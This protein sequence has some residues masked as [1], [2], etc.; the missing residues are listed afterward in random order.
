MGGPH[1]VSTNGPPNIEVLH[2]QHQQWQHR[3]HPPPSRPQ[4]PD[5]RTPTSAMVSQPAVF[6]MPFDGVDGS[7]TSVPYLPQSY[8]VYAPRPQIQQPQRVHS[9]PTH[10]IGYPYVVVIKHFIDVMLIQSTSRLLSY[11]FCHVQRAPHHVCIVVYIVVLHK[12]EFIFNLAQN[13]G[14][15]LAVCV[16][17]EEFVDEEQGDGSSSQSQSSNRGVQRSVCTRGVC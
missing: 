5:L 7:L 12:Y 15:V 14:Q 4:R 2:V 17:E 16:Y 10:V 3:H 8:P 6:G 1:G 11:T 9:P 13:L